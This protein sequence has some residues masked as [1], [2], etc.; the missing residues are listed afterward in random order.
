MSETATEL[1]LQLGKQTVPAG[2]AASMVLRAP[3]A[4]LVHIYPPGPTLGARYALTDAPVVLGRDRECDIVI[5]DPSVS[6]RHARFDP[7]DDGYTLIDLDST[8]GTAVNKVLVSRCKLR[9]GNDLRFG[10]CI[11][12]FLA[13]S[14]VEAQYHE[15]IYR[16]SVSD[17]LTQ[18]PNR[19]YL[20]Q[21]LE[22]ELFRSAR[23]RTPLALVLFDIDHFKVINDE[24]GHVV[25][26]FALQELAACV[27]NVLRKE[28]LFARYGGE[29]FA[30]VLPQ[31]SLQEGAFVAER[32]R[33]LVERHT[34]SFEQRTFAVTVSLGVAATQG[35]EQLTPAEFI[36]K[37]DENMY[38]AKE[39]GRNRVA[40]DKPEVVGQ[41]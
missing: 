23:Y 38:L 9:D 20:L 6:R 8:N 7:E 22:R 36:R 16:L 21:Y 27:K 4:Y 12:R 24:F 29:E 39:R 17:P 28:S 34:F 18:I 40:A 25:G 5:D 41:P 14:N 33:A 13:S 32:I 26:D 35:E 15:E 31:A 2:A 30:V 11:F 3:G 19:R 1:T 37:A 10:N